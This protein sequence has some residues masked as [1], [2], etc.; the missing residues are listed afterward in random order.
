MRV[1]A[2]HPNYIDAERLS[3]IVTH[4]VGRTNKTVP[5]TTWMLL[6]LIQLLVG[7]VCGLSC[8]ASSF[9]CSVGASSFLFLCQEFFCSFAICSLFCYFLRPEDG[10][11]RQHE[12]SL[13]QVLDR[14]S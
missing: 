11:F 3:A 7:V 13:E 12:P 5:S 8:G 1:C 10:G 9:L 6:S 14:V 4:Q 2:L